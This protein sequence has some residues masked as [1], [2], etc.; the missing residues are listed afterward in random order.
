MEESSL[1]A[2]AKPL[3]N[4]TLLGHRNHKNPLTGYISPLSA[5]H[6]A[7]VIQSW[8]H[9][10]AYRVSQLPTS[11][12]KR[13]LATLKAI[14]PA[15]TAETCHVL[16]STGLPLELMTLFGVLNERV[17]GPAAD[18]EISYDRKSCNP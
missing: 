10:S 8:Y 7:I 16:T 5:K 1:V 15:V 9:Q 17:R 2:S 4:Y 3:I 6:T 13:S 11:D 14:H 18:I 12:K